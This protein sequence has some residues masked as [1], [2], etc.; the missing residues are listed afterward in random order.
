MNNNFR[1]DMTAMFNYLRS[2]GERGTF[3]ADHRFVTILGKFNPGLRQKV[4]N[5][6]EAKG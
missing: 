4:A 2:L 3:I 6:N 5:D 1:A